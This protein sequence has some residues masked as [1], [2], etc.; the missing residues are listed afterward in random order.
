MNRPKGRPYGRDTTG[1]C[2]KEARD[3]TEEQ[4]QRSNACLKGAYIIVGRG[5]P[6]GLVQVLANYLFM[7]G[8][9]TSRFQGSGVIGRA[10]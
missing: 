6:S 1:S 9:S 4:A 8:V 10:E 3:E 7:G 5:L 2:R